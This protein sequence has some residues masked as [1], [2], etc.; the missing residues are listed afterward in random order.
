[1][2]AR[3]ASLRQKGGRARILQTGS[4]AGSAL[5]AAQERAVAANRHALR[6]LAA[7]PA[8]KIGADI[9][10]LKTSTDAA[11]KTFGVEGSGGGQ[12]GGEGCGP[13]RAGL[14]PRACTRAELLGWSVSR[15]IASAP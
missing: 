14:K 7:L 1:M 8:R 9:S 12:S 11:V 2:R 3:W 10:E 6:L 5:Q 13:A 15:R 4:P